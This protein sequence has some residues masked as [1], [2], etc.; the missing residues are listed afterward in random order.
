MSAF[1]PVHL[2]RAVT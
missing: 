2:G 1:F